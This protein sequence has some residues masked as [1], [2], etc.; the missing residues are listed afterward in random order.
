M[1]YL[2]KI[3]IATVTFC[4]I[5]LL[6]TLPVMACCGGGGG[7]GGGGGREGGSSVFDNL[8]NNPNLYP[9]KRPPRRNPYN[10]ESFVGSYLEYGPAP[11][12]R[13]PPVSWYS[14]HELRYQKPPVPPRKPTRSAAFQHLDG[15]IRKAAVLIRIQ[16]AI[17]R[18]LERMPPDKITRDLR[19]ELLD[20]ARQSVKATK[21]AMT[22]RVTR[23]LITGGRM[24]IH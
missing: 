16:Q 22:E 21:Q 24:N 18:E 7:G 9:P 12:R 23:N 19:R 1:R 13:P 6:S 20:L 5:G 4:A 2:P 10:A 3:T 11:T 17:V 14:R 15:E 8:R